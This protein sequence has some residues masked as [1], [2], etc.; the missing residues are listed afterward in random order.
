MNLTKLKEDI[1]KLKKMDCNICG[2]IVNLKLQAYKKVVEAVKE[3]PLRFYGTAHPNHK[4]W[5]QICE[6]LGV[7]E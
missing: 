5:Q 7:G 3:A 2:E 6:L 4:I 1:E